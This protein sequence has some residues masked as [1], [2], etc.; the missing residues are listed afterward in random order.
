MYYED[1]PLTRLESPP[2]L[3][4][5]EV[6]PTFVQ[7]LKELNYVLDRFGYA[8]KAD[9]PVFFGSRLDFAYSAFGIAPPKGIAFDMWI[10]Y[11]PVRN[12]RGTNDYIQRF[13]DA[14]FPLCVFFRR[15]YVYFSEDMVRYLYENY[16][17]YDYGN[18]T[19]HVRKQGV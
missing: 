19:L 15:D 12:E 17:V 2:L 7:V 16:D 1:A 4:G 18:L 13:K 11:N 9:A 3:K 8:G 5:V 6:G 10:Y 14:K